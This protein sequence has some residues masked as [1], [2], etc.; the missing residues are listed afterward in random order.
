M[1][2]LNAYTWMKDHQVLFFRCNYWVLWCPV[3]FSSM[4]LEMFEH[5]TNLTNGN[6]ANHTKLPNRAYGIMEFLSVLL[7]HLMVSMGSLIF[8]RQLGKEVIVAYGSS[9]FSSHIPLPQTL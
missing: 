3:S 8:G 6:I 1:Q 4:L 9:S 5:S 7:V 2:S